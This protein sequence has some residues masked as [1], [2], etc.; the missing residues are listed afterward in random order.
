MTIDWANFTP[1]SALAG[2]ALLG[3]A[4]IILLLC[5]GRIAGISGIL[6]GL[7]PPKA[8]DISW[9]VAFILGLVAAPVIY[10]L[11]TALPVIQIDA[12]WPVLIVAGLLV[13]IGTRYG[14]GCTSGH[15]VCGLARFSPRSL[16]ATLSFMFAGFGTVWL[17]RH[18]FV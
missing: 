10:S 17:V 6:G 18:L 13:G 3:I 11:F 14:A 8:G 9:R 4:V 16:L 5:N 2:G 7:L 1:Y 15:G 12:G